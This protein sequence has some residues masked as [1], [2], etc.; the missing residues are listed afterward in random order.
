MRRAL[1]RAD[2]G[3]TTMVKRIFV[4]GEAGTTGLQIRQRLAHHG[5]VELLT[6]PEHQRKDPAA[7]ADAMSRADLVILCLP[8]DAAREAASLATG[9]TRVID[10]SSAHRTHPDWVYGFPEWKPGHAA[11]IREARLVTNPGCY[12]IASVALLAPL[13]AERLLP[14]DHPVTINAVSGYSGGGK[15]LIDRYENPG[16]E[17]PIRGTF[18]VYSLDLEHKH[19]GEIEKRSGLA[20]P[21]LFVPATARYRQGM[22]VQIPLPLWSLT[23]AVSAS[24][25]QECLASHYAGA[26]FVR[27]APLHRSD[28]SAELDAESLNGTNL[29]ELHVFA[30]EARAQVVLCAILDNLGKGASGQAVQNLNLMLGLDPATALLERLPV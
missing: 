17:R 26:S 19:S 2:P 30:N 25:L 16:N 7:R 4:D 24:Q 8:D 10:A 23:K 14:A 28:R 20:R 15:A 12:A 5:G 13:V 29:L 22:L 9:S 1:M 18:R 3:G 11:R 21:P 6:L 27:V